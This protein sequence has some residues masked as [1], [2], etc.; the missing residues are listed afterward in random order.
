MPV[1]VLYV[2]TCIAP[3]QIGSEKSLLQNEELF[4][5]SLA[6]L[7]KHGERVFRAVWTVQE[8]GGRPLTK[9]RAPG[10]RSAM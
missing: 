1:I 10:G 8:G 9:G 6:S 7:L 3:A 5:T 2:M 4:E